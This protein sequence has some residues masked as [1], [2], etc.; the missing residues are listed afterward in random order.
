M[1]KSTAGSMKT[2]LLILYQSFIQNTTLR[3]RR[4]VNIVL[5]FPLFLVSLHIEQSISCVKGC[6]LFGFCFVCFWPQQSTKFVSGSMS[7]KSLRGSLLCVKSLKSLS[8]C[9]CLCE[10]VCLWACVSYEEQG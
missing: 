5:N 6:F 7:V 1:A 4:L 3:Q 10:S 9:M 8:V 2:L